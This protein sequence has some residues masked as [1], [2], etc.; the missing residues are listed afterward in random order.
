M[1]NELILFLLIAFYFAVPIALY[2]LRCRL[3]AQFC[4]YMYASTNFRKFYCYILLLA[5]IILHFVYYNTM[6]EDWG[7]MV[8]TIPMLM[9][10]SVKRQE[11]FLVRLKD[12]R[13]ELFVLCGL[14]LI[15]SLA[16]HLFTLGITLAILSIGVAFYPSSEIRAMDNYMVTAE[17]CKSIM[18]KDYT[19]LINVY[20]W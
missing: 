5:V 13:K 12:N 1:D 16:P 15:T 14:A 8:S 4:Y 20:F 7:L 11:N 10:F 6:G 17:Y 2:R 19:Q 3:V 9:M 18:T